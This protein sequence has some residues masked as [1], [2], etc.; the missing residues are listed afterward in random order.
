MIDAVYKVVLAIAR[1]TTHID[2]ASDVV[3]FGLV[4]VA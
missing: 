2:E 4:E 1:G 3:A